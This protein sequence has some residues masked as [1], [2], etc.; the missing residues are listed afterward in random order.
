MP[1]LWINRLVLT[2]SRQHT[3]SLSSLESRE[4]GGTR[5]SPRLGALCRS[6]VF[7]LYGMGIV[8]GRGGDYARAA[9]PRRGHPPFVDRS[10]GRERYHGRVQ[11]G[12]SAT[13]ADRVRKRLWLAAGGEASR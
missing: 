11:R 7:S 13:R 8:V 2:A 10:A 12:T 3:R 5:G 6:R 1:A 9:M 4:R